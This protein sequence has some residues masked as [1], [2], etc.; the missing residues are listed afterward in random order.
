[1]SVRFGKVSIG[2]PS[3][4][5]DYTKKQF[6]EKFAAD[7]HPDVDKAWDYVKAELKKD[8][9]REHTTGRVGAQ[10]GESKEDSEP[11]VV[12]SSKRRR[13]KKADN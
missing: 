13:S 11:T 4:F 7:M 2:N 9:N 10:D 8:G 6:V 3:A 5:K 12:K 1:M